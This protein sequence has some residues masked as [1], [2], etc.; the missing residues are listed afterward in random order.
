MKKILRKIKRLFN[1]A[2]GKDFFLKE[3]YKCVYKRLGSQ[4]GGW[5]IVIDQLTQDSIIYSVGVG[6]DISFDLALI[7]AFDLEIHA[8]DPTPKS[9]KWV[10]KQGFTSK[11][12][13]HEFGLS[14]FD[15][16]LTF[17][18]PENTE[19]VSYTTLERPSTN[20]DAISLPVKRL[21]TIMKEL[22]HSK[23]DVLKMDIEG[24]EY[25]VI[26][27]IEMTDIR[28]KQLLIEFHHRFP[29]VGIDKTKESLKTLKNIGYKLFSVSESGEEFSFIYKGG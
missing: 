15:G 12:I 7:D 19:H 9:I 11:F 21:A 23:L 27:D 16:M 1:V 5:D 25:L 10:K 26:K 29:N 3:D 8:F 4:Y 22:R 18:P 17:R 13:M 28:P 20:D 6:E 2:I 14:D 24:S